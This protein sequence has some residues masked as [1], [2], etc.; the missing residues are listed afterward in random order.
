MLNDSVSPLFALAIFWPRAVKLA[1]VAFVFANGAGKLKDQTKL[2]WG[3]TVPPN[4]LFVLT[5][6][7]FAA[8]IPD[9]CKAAS[10]SSR[11]VLRGDWTLT[12]KIA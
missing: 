6:D 9:P 3:G 10:T 8:V 5:P 11:P 7:K 2:G 1:T 12:E 4:W